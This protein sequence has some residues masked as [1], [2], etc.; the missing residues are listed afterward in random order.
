VLAGSSIGV[1]GVELGRRVKGFVIIGMIRIQFRL[2]LDL[3]RRRKRWD[4]AH[5]GCERIERTIR[6]EDVGERDV[7]RRSRSRHVS[8]VTVQRA[9]HRVRQ[10]HVAE[11]PRGQRREGIRVIALRIVASKRRHAALQ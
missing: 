8:H 2:R 6:E 9:R 11:L 3:R 4:G 1:I 10:M 7:L 5:L